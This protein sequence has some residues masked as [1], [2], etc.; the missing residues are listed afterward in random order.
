VAISCDF[1]VR[2][3][4][5]EDF[6]DFEGVVVAFGRYDGAGIHSIDWEC[7]HLATGVG[8]VGSLVYGAQ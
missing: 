5:V 1:L 3:G 6:E 2:S 8:E 4:D 7:G